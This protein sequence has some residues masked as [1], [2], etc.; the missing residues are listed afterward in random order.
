MGYSH[1][2]KKGVMYY[3]H[4]RGKL[5]FFSKDSNNSIDL[6]GGYHVVENPRTGLPL[7]KKNK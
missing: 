4:Q 1:K 2:N 6:P 7:I 3:L 5:F